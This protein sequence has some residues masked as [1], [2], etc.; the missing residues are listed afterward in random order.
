MARD[1]VGS[2]ILRIASEIRT[3]RGA[4]RRSATSRWA[5]SPPRSSPFPTSCA[6]VSC[7]RSRPGRRT[8]RF[9]R[10]PPAPRGG[11]RVLPED[12]FA[13]G[14]ARVGAH[15]GR[16]EAAHLRDLRGAGRP[17]RRGALPGAELEQQPLL[18][19]GGSKRDP[20]H[21][22]PET[23]SYPPPDCWNRICRARA[24]S[25]STRRSIPRARCCRR[26]RSSGSA[27][28]SCPRRAACAGA[29]EAALR[30]LRSGLLDAD[31]RRGQA[32]DAGAPGPADGALHGLHRRHL[33]AFA[34]TGLRSAGGS[35]RPR[36]SPR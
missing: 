29:G 32:R 18:P 7:A 35:V 28:P 20:A 36:S 25:R 23:G 12:P 8:T 19:S 2:E 1:L 16:L 26:T 17:G 6:K 24:S 27:T 3:P 4:A 21:T 5:T 13:G 33:Q 9:G 15:R 10:R 34:A 31:V 11:A 30:P 22:R 14:A